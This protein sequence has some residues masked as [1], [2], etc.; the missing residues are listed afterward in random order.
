VPL[1]GPRRVLPR[2][3]SV[4]M[5]ASVRARAA[6]VRVIG[7]SVRVQPQDDNRYAVVI[8]DALPVRVMWC[9]VVCC[10]RHAHA[11]LTCHCSTSSML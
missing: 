2:V 10:E 5:L 6:A 3:A 7:V 4:Q 1:A 9:G 8:F 11:R